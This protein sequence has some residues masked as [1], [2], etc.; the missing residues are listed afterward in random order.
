[1]TTKLRKIPLRTTKIKVKQ[2]D[3]TEKEMPFVF[4][5]HLIGALN[6]PPTDERSGQPRGFGPVEM[7]KRLK[8]VKLIENAKDEVLL[9]NS[10]WSELKTCVTNQKWMLLDEAITDFS[11]A[12]EN[13]EEVEVE[14]K[15]E[16]KKTRDAM[17]AA[18][19]LDDTKD[20]KEGEK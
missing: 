10:D 3:G 8:I 13:A 6:Q 11:D 12:V 1:M 5:E 4:S 15:K 14:E 19:A 18:Q 7:R 17:L 9:E 2:Q 16:S 20:K